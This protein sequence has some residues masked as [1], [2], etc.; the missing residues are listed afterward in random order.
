MQRS[1]KWNTWASSSEICPFHDCLF[2]TS[3]GEDPRI[4]NSNMPRKNIRK[5][6]PKRKC[7]AFDWPSSDK[8]LLLHI[9]EVLDNQLDEN[10]Q[11]KSEDFCS[12]IFTH[13]KPKTLREGITVK[14]GDES[15]ALEH[16]SLTHCVSWTCDCTLGFS[17]IAFSSPCNSEHGCSCHTWKCMFLH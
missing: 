10:F 7:F 14:S 5:F 17:V 3:I 12:Y 1:Q 13:A 4:Q 11:K 8:K 15:L 9:E 2:L 6:F 16:M